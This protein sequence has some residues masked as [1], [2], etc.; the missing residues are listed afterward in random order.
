[1][2]A[3][4]SHY[5][6]S[7]TSVEDNMLKPVIA[8]TAILALAGSS[9]V[10][11]QQRNGGHGGFGDGGPRAEHQHHR[12]SADDIS[13]FADARIAALKAGLELTPDQAKNWPAFE[14]ALRNM[15]QL[16]VQRMQARHAHDQQSQSQTQ[17]PATPF[18]RM[19]RRADK[20]SKRGAA[21]KQIADS[22]AP[23][24]QSLTDAQKGRFT[25]LARMLRPHHHEHAG[26]GGNSGGWRQGRGYGRDGGG[27]DG[28]GWGHGGHRL[29]QD[30]QGFGH[31]GHQF[32]RDGQDGG[33][34]GRDFGQNGRGP[35]GEMHNSMGNDGDQ[36]SHL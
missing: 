13:A 28:R 25:M 20:M 29:G 5:L 21:L 14:G 34:G 3:G 11:A 33:H 30:G 9:I 16:R 36:D 6:R 12:L 17:T 1:L 24:Y 15:V 23:L 31:G 22:G 18:D 27:Q 2:T 26:N 19:A 4:A 35:T 32:G 8:A 10:Y 7:L